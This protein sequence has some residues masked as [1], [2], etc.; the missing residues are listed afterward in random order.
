MC[1]RTLARRATVLVA[2]VLFVV[3]PARANDAAHEMA[4]KFARDAE[5]SQAAAKADAG[6]RAA[7]KKKRELEAEQAKKRKAAR[8]A[9]EAKKVADAKKA[10]A[11]A[12][13]RRAAEVHKAEEEEM[14]AHAR[15]EAAEMRTADEHAK[16]AEEARRLIERAERERAKAEALLAS[17]GA[18]HESSKPDEARNARELGD[19]RSAP[20]TREPSETR[21]KGPEPAPSTTRRDDNPDKPAPA[22]TADTDPA[23]LAQVRAEETRRLVEKLNRVREIRQARRAAQSSR[24]SDEED[25]GRGLGPPPA[26]SANAAPP[27]SAFEP[28]ASTPADDAAR[29]GANPSTVAIPSV[30]PTAASASSAAPATA[31]RS[32][33]GAGDIAPNSVFGSRPAAADS[34][35]P[36]GLVARQRTEPRVAVLLVLA[37]G[38]YGIRRGS[39]TADPLL[40]APEGC[41]VSTGPDTPA[42][43]MP[44]WMALGFGNTWGV[45]AGAC[46]RSLG[47]VFRGVQIRDWPSPF[48]PV[49]LHILRHDRRRIQVVMGDSACR[50]DEGRIS[51]SAGIYAEDYAMWI[52]PESVAASVGGNALK[53]AVSEG[54]NGPRA[55]EISRLGR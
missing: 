20:A 10:T 45:R 16:L 7:E 9:L 14:L 35:P 18:G 4:E 19:A 24:A 42:R 55:A 12:A 15:R 48:Q 13:A 11:A 17:G 27:K 33:L 2:A 41:Y 26:Q 21:A 1:G 38:N 49:D 52:V 46:N 22:P 37:P 29:P 44:G 31:E 54:L 28:P 40:C 8:E 39:K 34:A 43:L 23:K 5:R 6:R 47:C 50:A 30:A 32:G 36:T 25:S 53:R 51:C 3:G